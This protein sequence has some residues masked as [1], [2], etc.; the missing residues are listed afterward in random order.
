MVSE[1]YCEINGVPHFKRTFNDG[2]V[3]YESW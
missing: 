2:S 3:V 1:E